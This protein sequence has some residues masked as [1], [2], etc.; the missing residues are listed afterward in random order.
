MPKITLLF[1]SLHVVLLLCLLVPISRHRYRLRIGIG[2]GGDAALLRKI[3]VHANFIEYAPLALLML[4]L[5]ELSGLAA[6]WLWS[7]GA[8]LLLGRVMHAVG[9][10]RKSGYSFGRFYGTALTWLV[11]VAMVLA[12]LW[13]LAT[14]GT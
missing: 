13:L 11:L 3:R 5:L 1:A 8:A 2:D 9:F 4:G 10:S 7:L 12:G 14:Q 6:A